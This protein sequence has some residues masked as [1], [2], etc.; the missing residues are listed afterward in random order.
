[1]AT[2]FLQDVYQGLEPHVTRGEIKRIAVVQEIEKS[3]LADVNQ[4]SFGFQFPTVSAGATYAPKR[5]LGTAT[6]EADGS[7]CFRVPAG[8]PIYF[9]ALDAEGRALQ[10]MRTFTHLMPG[11][12]QGCIGCHEPRS[13]TAPMTG[14]PL[15]FGRPPEDLATPEWG[16]QGFS[17]AHIVQPVLD[18][19]CAACHNPGS[20]KGGIDLTGDRTDF[21][22]VSY[23]YLA[24]LGTVGMDPDMG[25]I[26]RAEDV[27]TYNPYT[28]WIYTYN[29]AEPN[30]LMIEPR[31]WGSPASR[32]SDLLI[33]GHPDDDGNPRV[34]LSESERRR[35][36]TWI[37]LN[38]PY[39]GTSRFNYPERMGCRR[40]YPEQLDAVL[41]EVGARRCAECHGHDDAGLVNIPRDFYVR[42]TGAE[43]NA[44]LRAPLAA[45]AGGLQACGEAVFAS[46]EDPDYRAIL[47]TFRD[48]LE[49]LERRPR[50]DMVEDPAAAGLLPACA[51]ALPAA[52]AAGRPPA[53][54]CSDYSRGRVCIVS[55]VGEIVWEHPAPSAQDI[56]LLP[57]G[58]RVFSHFHGVKEVRPDGSLV[59]EFTCEEPN[60]VQSCQALPDGR[61]LIGE[62]GACRLIEVD[63]T[64]AIVKEIPVPVDTT[65][66]HMQF[67]QVRKTPAGTYLVACTGDG[68]V[69]ELD[70]RGNVL[71]TIE[72]GPLVYGA[73][74]LPDGNVLIGC[75]EGH[76]IIEVDPEGRVV[77]EVN[78]ND[79]P[80]NPLRFVAGLQRLANGNTVVCNWD[81]FGF[82][83]QQ[84]QVFEITREKEVV[85]QIHDNERFGSITHMNIAD[86]DV[87]ALMR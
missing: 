67:R 39:Y 26:P 19:H 16:D 60:E 1:M 69:R 66:L 30:I 5:V 59:W 34:A 83:G 40:Q 65:D 64:G 81:G 55:E 12:T 74:P 31:Q 71:R 42:V 68:V 27:F 28:R 76:R 7:A 6:V 77:W 3:Q 75:G 2:L 63:G 58:N 15:A 80:G 54:A 84:P 56:W 32:L 51:D 23:E 17:Y 62:L 4:R 85:W 73:V 41:Q 50:M 47:A 61:T 8:L 70:D 35:I 52:P 25:G 11:E 53:F 78:E 43:N 13:H 44:F 18:R 14:T 9:M 57:S 79:I 48:V 20:Q 36:H 33:S 82:V 22:N 49:E 29:G 21:F 46:A 87:Y 45:A 10:R 37:D 24:R 72:A 38:V 86:A